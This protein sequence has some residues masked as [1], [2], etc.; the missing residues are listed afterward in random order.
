VRACV[1]DREE[2]VD[3]VEDYKFGEDNHFSG[4][5][6]YCDTYQIQGKVRSNFQLLK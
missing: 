6:K 3:F 2:V 5:V 1:S 4:I